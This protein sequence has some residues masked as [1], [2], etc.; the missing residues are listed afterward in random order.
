MESTAQG[1]AELLSPDRRNQSG[2]C[3]SRPDDGVAHDLGIVVSVD[4]LPRG[5]VGGV[6]NLEEDLIVVR[7]LNDLRLGLAIDALLFRAF[8][9]DACCQVLDGHVADDLALMPDGESVAGV[10]LAHDAGSCALVDVGQVPV[11]VVDLEYLLAE[12]RRRD[13]QETLLGLGYAQHL[14]REVAGFVHVVQVDLHAKAPCRAH[15]GCG[16]GEA[17]AAQVLEAD[18]DARLADQSE[19]IVVGL[20]EDILQEGVRDL[21]CAAVGLLILFSQCL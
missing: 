4:M 18:L 15:L 5:D 12:L 7:G 8:V 6:Q 14:G 10:Y 1:Q 16:A 13:D 2:V 11:L 17:A 9:A 20:E 3:L 21:H 19:E